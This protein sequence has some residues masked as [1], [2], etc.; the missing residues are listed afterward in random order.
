MSCMVSVVNL[1]GYCYR[2]CFYES[3]LNFSRATKESVIV[4]IISILKME[5]F[6][7]YEHWFSKTGVRF[8]DF[9][10]D[11]KTVSR[12]EIDDANRVIS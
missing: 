8:S 11:I 5:N 10:G 9:L 7:P 2:N 6:T 1:Y 4:Y 3:G 12:V